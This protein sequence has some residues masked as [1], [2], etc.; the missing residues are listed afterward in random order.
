MPDLLRLSA[1]LHLTGLIAFAGAAHAGCTR[2]IVMP[3]VQLPQAPATAPD[4][5][6]L[7]R[8]VREVGAALGCEFSFPAVPRPRLHQML[9]NRQAD[10]MLPAARDPERDAAGVFVSMARMPL[11]LVMRKGD[12]RRPSDLNALVADAGLR[13]LMVRGQTW[14]GALDRAMD[15]QGATRVHRVSD[16]ITVLRMLVA[17][18]ADFTVI[19]PDLFRG[20]GHREELREVVP[21][22]ESLPLS[23]LPDIEA[24]AYVSKSLNVSD[25]ALVLKVFST[26]AVRKLM[27]VPTSVAASSAR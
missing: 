1:L 2:T 7:H 27:Q 19:S 24:G 10:V 17:D 16:N 11:E 20:L 13:G 3:M 18:R 21:Q 12:P 4:D 23:G 5:S 15:E 6:K 25:R 22:L 8:T 26:D 14:G 9:L